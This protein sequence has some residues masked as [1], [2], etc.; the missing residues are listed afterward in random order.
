MLGV[1]Q[2]QA[3][4]TGSTFI[5]LFWRKAETRKKK[6]KP[7][8]IV[9]VCWIAQGSSLNRYELKSHK[10]T[11]VDKICQ[12]LPPQLDAQYGISAHFHYQNNDRRRLAIPWSG[13]GSWQLSS[14]LLD[15]NHCPW[16]STWRDTSKDVHGQGGVFTVIPWRYVDPVGGG[17]CF[18]GGGGGVT[19]WQRPF[20]WLLLFLFRKAPS[21][22]SLINW[23][24]I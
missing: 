14:S 21:H 20:G 4:K 5:L 3:G 10:T 24:L 18:T 8:A 23:L 6:K 9:G 7:P 13:V 11:H 12:T 19:S 15:D 16:K 2:P 22:L 1:I 17:L